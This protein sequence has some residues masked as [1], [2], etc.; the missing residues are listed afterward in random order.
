MSTWQPSSIH[1]WNGTSLLRILGHFGP[2]NLL[3]VSKND[4][5]ERCFLEQ[6]GFMQSIVCLII[7]RDNGITIQIMIYQ[8]YT[9]LILF[10]GFMI[11]T[12]LPIEKNMIVQKF[13][14]ILSTF[15]IFVI[16]PLFYLNGD[17]NFRNKVQNE[18]LWRALKKELF[19]M[20]SQIQ[21]MPE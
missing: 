20:T 8:V 16:Q 1:F 12:L 9:E 7:F 6:F 19:P 21:P 4:D 17:F 13:A 3:R 14:G 18:G 11:L 5:E 2:A 15:S 10:L